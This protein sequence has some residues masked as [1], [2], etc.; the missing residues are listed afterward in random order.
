MPKG[1]NKAQATIKRQR[2][3]YGRT[4]SEDVKSEQVDAPDD[5]TNKHPAALT[6]V[7]YHHGVTVGLPDYCGERVYVGLEP[8]CKTNV[9]SIDL[10]YDWAHDWVH[11]RLDK[12]V[13]E[14]NADTD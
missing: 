11:E 4:V 6:R 5:V 12:E 3:K 14:I 9:D 7:I 1:K 10:T 2:T 8:V 13:G